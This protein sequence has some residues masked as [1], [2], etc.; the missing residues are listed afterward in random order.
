MNPQSLLHGNSRFPKGRLWL[1]AV[2]ATIVLLGLM[3]ISV[4]KE[5]RLMAPSGW[6]EPIADLLTSQINVGADDTVSLSVRDA[7]IDDVLDEIARQ[8]HADLFRV[9]SFPERLSLRIERQ[10]LQAA[11][12]TVLKDH[13]YLLYTRTHGQIGCQRTP[14]RF[15]IY[16]LETGDSDTRPQP[17]EAA[18]VCAPAPVADGIPAVTGGAGVNTPRDFPMLA[19]SLTLKVPEVREAMVDALTEM[20]SLAAIRALGE[21]VHDKNEDISDEAISALAEIDTEAAAEALATGL[22]AGDTA[23]RLRVVEALGD[24][25]SEAAQRALRQAADDANEQVRQAASDY[26]DDSGEAP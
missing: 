10:P 17:N 1:L 23:L 8:A 22:E 4:S 26:L 19:V 24:M 5:N 16:S 12:M 20:N 21:M 9:G 14:D 13:N 25:R 18:S 2:A 3:R 11:L 7:P 6:S 15:W